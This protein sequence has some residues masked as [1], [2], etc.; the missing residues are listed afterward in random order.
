MA[1]GATPSLNNGPPL[2]PNLQPAPQA[3]VGG[4]AGQPQQADPN[5]NASLQQQVIQKM[6]FVEQTLSGVATMMPA[7]AGP[8][9]AAIDQL[10]KGVGAA[11]AAGAGPPSSQGPM[12]GGSMLMTGGQGMTPGG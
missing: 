10:R 7:A 9:N 12:G 11:L 5:G 1:A 2:P 8:I 6:M 4:L 3:T